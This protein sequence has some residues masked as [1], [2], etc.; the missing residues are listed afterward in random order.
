MLLARR[1]ERLIRPL[2]DPL[3]ADVDPRAGRHL[4][5]HRQA[6][7]LEPPELVPR[8]P[9]RHEQRVRDQDARRTLVRREDADGLARLHEQR[10]VRAELEQRAD[11]RAQRIVR[12]R[13]TTRAAV[14]DELL[15]VL[16]DLGV[17]IVQQHAQRRLRRPLARV[18]LRP[19]RRADPRQIAAQRLDPRRERLG[20]AHRSSPTSASTAASERAVADRAGDRLD[21]RRERPVVAQPRRELAHGRA[22]RAHAGAGLERRDGTRRP[23]RP[24]AARSRARARSSRAPATPSALRRCPSTRDPP[25]PRSSGSNLSRQGGTRPCSPRRAPPPRTAGS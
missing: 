16:G 1:G 3:R 8:R 20:H 7:G 19:A 4:P 12:A 11:D 21:V 15:R 5:E 6:L 23:A 14:D 13:R 9:L 2:Q 25:V 10:L 18:Q 22:R 17:E 24:R